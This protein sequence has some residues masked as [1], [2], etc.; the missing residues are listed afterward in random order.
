MS[1]NGTHQVMMGISKRG[2]QHL[3]SLLGSRCLR[4]GAN[5]RRPALLHTSRSPLLPR[6][7]CPIAKPTSYTAVDHQL[8]N[9]PVLPRPLMS[10]P[11]DAIAWC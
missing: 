7:G 9:G 4:R 1:M 5:L 11:S 10:P 6:P 2:S 3:H 8:N